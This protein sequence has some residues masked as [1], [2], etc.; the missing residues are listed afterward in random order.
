MLVLGGGD[1]LAVREILRYPN[2][3]TVT[4]VDLDGVRRRDPARRA[5]ARQLEQAPPRRAL[6]GAEVEIIPAAI[7]LTQPDARALGAMRHLTFGDDV[8]SPAFRGVPARGA[9]GGSPMSVYYADPYWSLTQVM[10]MSS[11]SAS[12]TWRPRCSSRTR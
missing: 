4:L 10:L 5:V 12:R 6:V 3:Q 7:R 11:V 9:Y 8:A 1:G 2:V